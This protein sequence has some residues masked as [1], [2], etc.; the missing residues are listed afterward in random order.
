MNI[1][2]ATGAT[3]TFEHLYKEKTLSIIDFGADTKASPVINTSAVNEAIKAAN[4]QG[5]GTVVIPAGEFKVY[6]IRLQS[7]VNLYLEKNAV[8][9]AAKTDITKSYQKQKS[10]G[11]NYDEPEVNLYAGLQDHGHTYFSN[12]LIYGE[13]LENIMIYGE[14]LINGSC[15]DE[16]TGYREYILQGGDPFDNPM[17]NENGH[18]GEWFGNKGIALV[19]CKNVVLKDFSILIGGHF[20]I[21]AEGVTNLLADHILVDTTR[22]A[23]DIDCC[24]NVTVVNSVFNSL[25]DDALV[26]K[27][28]YGA[29]IF[30]PTRNVL[31]E[32][33]K[34][35]GYDAGSVYAGKY[36]K[37]KLIATDRCGPTARVKLGTESTCGYDLV[38][39]KRVKFD[40]SRGFALEA[41]D[42]SDLSNIIFTDCEMDNVSSSPIFIRAGERGRFP[43][44][45]NS[46]E[47]VVNARKGNVRLDNVNWVLPN[48]EDYESYPAKRYIPSYERNQ[49]VTVDGHS[50][51]SVVNQ[52][53]P[54]RMNPGN[55]KEIDGNYYVMAYDEEAKSYKPDL[56]KEIPKAELCRYANAVGSDRMPRVS[57]IEISNIKIKNADPR[58]PMILM[59]LIDAPIQNVVMK[60]I[61]VEYRGGLTMEHAVEQR[62]LNTNW[63]YS[64]YE[65]KSSIQTLPWLV[66]TFFLK[67]EGL[68]P[69]VDWDEEKNC[70]R[71]DPYNVP[72]LPEVYPEPSNWGILPAYGLYARHVENLELSDITIRFKA[73]DERHAI[74]LD[75]V[76]KAIIQ[77][78]DANIAPDRSV[79][80]KVTNHFKRP[81]NFEY[82]QNEPYFTTT[83]TDLTLSGDISV[84][85]VTVNAPSPGTPQD[86]LYDMPTLPIPENGYHYEVKTEDYPI[87]QTVFRPFLST[88][89]RQRGTVGEEL[90]L[91]IT[92][93]NPATET[94]MEETDGFI[95]NEAVSNRD[96]VVEG[97]KN[98]VM[99]H[100]KNLPE[101]AV[102]DEASRILRWIPKK[103]QA[104]VHQ[105]C[106]EMDDGILVETAVLSIEVEEG[107]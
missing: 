68:L 13:H 66:N 5:G 72:E 47:E 14:G 53:K 89:D 84:E 65:T 103:E 19:R 6:T 12:S 104:G 98:Q 107:Q 25:T 49:T 60:N 30:M 24:Q 79:L 3:V 48:T 106:V 75:D 64:Q 87:P 54:A 50:K 40:R 92:V 59:G 20:A 15:I 83:V 11:G 81:T 46:E 69:R 74:V 57:N 88:P 33:C 82:V 8:L 77:N 34:V 10:E 26:M 86:S 18:T 94:T 17:R 102:F 1:K 31:I 95:Y 85:D 93:R 71:A 105:I 80:A 70:W 97:V 45:G 32:D 90:I 51:F 62:Q 27:A 16:E 56:S 35:S 99:L 44:T 21:I 4:Q 9:Q 28:S 23:F 61:E 67:S 7:N 63:K 55:L 52:E 100:V 73:E 78:L 101:G 22:D 36:T 76:K 2:Q 96:Y 29:G 43:V 91:T 38:T 42:I 58:Y 37:D 41:V 39:I